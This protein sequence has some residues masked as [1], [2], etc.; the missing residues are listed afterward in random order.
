M[1]DVQ[2]VIVALVIAALINVVPRFLFPII[3]RRIGEEGP[4]PTKE[5]RASGET[6]NVKT[7][8]LC[9]SVQDCRKFG[10]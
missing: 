1:V 10:P 9:P 4:L 8:T 6:G 3:G 7:L 5:E 2:R